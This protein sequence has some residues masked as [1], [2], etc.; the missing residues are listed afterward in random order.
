MRT[1][2]IY[3]LGFIAFLIGAT[4]FLNHWDRIWFFFTGRHWGYDHSPAPLRSAQA[5][6]STLSK[7]LSNDERK[8]EIQRAFTKAHHHFNR[9][10][11]PAAE[12]QL[13]TGLDLA[14]RFQLLDLPVV[15]E[16]YNLR[17]CIF[18]HRGLI[19]QSLKNHEAASIIMGKWAFGAVAPYADMAHA[20]ADNIRRCRERLGE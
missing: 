6:P 9:Q 12:A 5:A 10:R 4:M 20:Y 13:R 16:M 3:A 14:R 7:V 17:G 8:A 1:E 15:A 18:F 11:F 2:T 19:K